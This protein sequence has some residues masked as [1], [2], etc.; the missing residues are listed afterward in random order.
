MEYPAFFVVFLGRFLQK[1]IHPNDL[2]MKP[3]IL[4]FLVSI[5]IF[6]GL[7][8]TKLSFALF[9]CD[10][11]IVACTLFLKFDHSNR[12]TMCAWIAIGLMSLYEKRSM[13]LLFSYFDPGLKRVVLVT[14]GPIA[15]PEAT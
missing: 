2:S 12:I 5:P 3:S 9:D 15:M 14:I 7:I 11:H 6:I 13:L 8:D 10:F 1:I 4:P